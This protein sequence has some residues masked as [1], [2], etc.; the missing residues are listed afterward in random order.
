MT[1]SIS[2]K[3]GNAFLDGLLSPAE[4][5]KQHEADVIA[6]WRASL[7]DPYDPDYDA[8]DYIQWD[9]IGT[10]GSADFRHGFHW[11]GGEPWGRPTEYGCLYEETRTLSDAF[12]A[13]EKQII[14]DAYR[15]EQWGEPESRR[16][17]LIEDQHTV[18]PI[19]GSDPKDFVSAY[20]ACLPEQMRGLGMSVRIEPGRLVYVAV[21]LGEPRAPQAIRAWIRQIDPERFRL[22]YSTPGISEWV[23]IPPVNVTS[24]R[25]L[26]ALAQQQDPTESIDLLP[27]GLVGLDALR[28]GIQRRGDRIVVQAETG[29]AKT[30]LALTMAEALAARGHQVAWIATADEPRASIVARRLQRVGYSFDEAKRLVTDPGAL[31][32]CNPNLVVLDGNACTL[33]DAVGARPEFL[34]V[35]NIQKVRSVAGRGLSQQS[36][37]EPRLEVIEASGVTTVVTSRMVRGA[38]KRGGNRLE[39]SYGGSAV[40]GGATVLLDLVL[41]GDE[42]TV[43]MRKGRGPGEG[44]AFTL[45]LDRA[46]QTLTRAKVRPARRSRCPKPRHTAGRRS[47]LPSGR[48]PKP[49]TRCAIGWRVNSPRL[50]HRSTRSSRPEPS[51]SSVE[52]T[53]TAPHR[54]PLE[55]GC[56]DRHLYLRRLFWVP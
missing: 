25:T 3:T 48:D 52:S 21:W 1:H 23:S 45:T 8:G 42:L 37:V 15:G 9:D 13:D 14:R 10:I 50:G 2:T 33:E 43:T 29:N 51:R 49:S 54:K 4:I 53:Q 11:Y 6:R 36:A 12:T 26:A 30:A 44:Q 24:T 17:V 7:R 22:L 47:S 19:D 55:N 56:K 27:S 16:W 34:F 18:A 28:G 20:R 40:E 41:A 5:R 31:A 32:R 38:G 39:G 35:D 46:K